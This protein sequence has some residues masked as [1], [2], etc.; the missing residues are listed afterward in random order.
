MVEVN[1]LREYY[2]QKGN[3][4]GNSHNLLNTNNIVETSHEP[5]MFLGAPVSK[6]STNIQQI[7]RYCEVSQCKLYSKLNQGQEIDTVKP[8]H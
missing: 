8:N 1:F 4:N 3:A 2:G 7:S 5:T 6:H